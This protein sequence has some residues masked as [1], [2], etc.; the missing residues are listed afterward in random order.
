MH[1]PKDVHLKTDE[2][3]FGPAHHQIKEGAFL[4]RLKFVTVRVW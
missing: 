2:L 4:V 3:R 1:N